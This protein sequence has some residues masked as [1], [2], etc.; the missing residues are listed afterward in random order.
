MG[1]EIAQ[2]THW[3]NCVSSITGLF[4]KTEVLPQQWEK[5]FV[6]RQISSTQN[7]FLFDHATNLQVFEWEEQGKTDGE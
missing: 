6:E 7:N 2:I 1:A 5:F 4:I 3:V